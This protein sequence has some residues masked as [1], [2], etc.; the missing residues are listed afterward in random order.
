LFK[1]RTSSEE[2]ATML[3]VS[4]EVECS[5]SGSSL[6]GGS[7]RKGVATPIG[8]ASARGNKTASDLHNK[9]SVPYDPNQML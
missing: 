7:L 3:A 4:G 2:S 8:S 1:A 6:G 9:K 5:G